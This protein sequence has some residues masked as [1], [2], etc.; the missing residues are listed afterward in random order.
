[1][2][3]R[4]SAADRDILLGLLCK[5]S[6]E[7]LKT[8]IDSVA[9]TVTRPV[10]RPAFNPG[11]ARSACYWAAI[12]CERKR[13]PRLTPLSVLRAATNLQKK[14]SPIFGFP[15]LA[16]KTLCSLHY[17]QEKRR[18]ASADYSNFLCR[19]LEKH[20]F[21]NTHRDKTDGKI[22]IIP[23]CLTAHGV[24]RLGLELPK[25]PAHNSKQLFIT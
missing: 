23:Q 7:Q 16:V 11:Y 8:G 19:V 12:E 5:Y 1:M 6:A 25:K 14:I 2:A 21:W 22:I 13:G 24:S 15:P 20:Q 10:G 18:K 9:K 4:L 3:R 17:E